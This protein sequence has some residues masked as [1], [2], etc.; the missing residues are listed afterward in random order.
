MIGFAHARIKMFEAAEKRAGASLFGNFSS[1][2]LFYGAFS[3]IFCFY[4]LQLFIQ[5]IL[6]LR[7]RPPA[8][9]DTVPFKKSNLRVETFFFY[10]SLRY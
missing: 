4:L 3:Q 2:Y 1:F 5:K 9:H 6:I 10:H 7:N 8:F